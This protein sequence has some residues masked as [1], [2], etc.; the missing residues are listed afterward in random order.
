MRAK[1]YITCGLLAGALTLPVSVFALG[2]GKLTVQSGLGQP[3]SATIELTSAQKDELDTL[4]ARIADPA[5]YRDNNVQY[6]SAMSRARIV[7]EQSRER[8]T[9]SARNDFASGQR[10]L[11]RSPGRAQLGNRT[12]RARLHVPARSAE[13]HRNTGSRAGGADPR[14][15][16]FRCRRARPGRPRAPPLRAARRSAARRRGR[17]C[18]PGRRYTV[19]RGDTL[20]KIAQQTKPADVSLEQMLVALFRSNEN[21][22][23]ERNMNR[24]RTGQIV[25]VPQGRPDR[26]GTAKRGDAGRQGASLRLARLSRPRGRGCT[27]QPMRLRQGNRRAAGSRRRSRTRRAP[28]SRARISCASRAKRARAPLR[29]RRWPK[30]SPPR[31]RP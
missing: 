13:Q 22:F 14:P 28:R 23:D 27:A 7:V 29:E 15:G 12:R 6:P 26:G 30:I 20:S 2:L 19:K 10:R 11:P 5:V 3:L 1:P 25:T 9:L 31:T 17:A 4:R 18:W 8:R 21:A 16:R 24:L